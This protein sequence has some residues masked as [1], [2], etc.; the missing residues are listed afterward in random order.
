[1]STT[2]EAPCSSYRFRLSSSRLCWHSDQ[3][4]IPPAEECLPFAGEA[5]ELRW[6]TRS[7]DKRDPRGTR[8]MQW[9]PPGSDSLPP[10]PERQSATI[11]SSQRAGTHALAG[12]AAEKSAF[13][14]A[15]LQLRPKR[16]SRRLRIQNGPG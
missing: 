14:E 2:G 5:E 8:R 10:R 12:R 1:M 7:V 4:N 9:L 6:E 13:R 11:D 3:Q 15:V 16:L